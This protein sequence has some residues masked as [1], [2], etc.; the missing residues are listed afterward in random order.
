MGALNVL[1][2][3]KGFPLVAILASSQLALQSVVTHFEGVLALIPNV[4]LVLLSKRVPIEQC[5]PT[6]S[7]GLCSHKHYEDSNTLLRSLLPQTLHLC[8]LTRTDGFLLAGSGKIHVKMAL[9]WE[10]RTC[11]TS[12]VWHKRSHS[13][14]EFLLFFN[15]SITETLL[16]LELH[17]KLGI[18]YRTILSRDPYCTISQGVT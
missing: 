7:S 9:I 13:L 1:G 10:H 5:F 14:P 11:V 8:Q 6:P 4:S 15:H 3:G 17:R 12:F 2:E 18:L 16:L